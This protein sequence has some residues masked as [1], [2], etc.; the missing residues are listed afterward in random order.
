MS[1]ISTVTFCVALLAGGSVAIAGSGVSY[2]TPDS[3]KWTAGTGPAKGS[4]STT[5]TGN[6]GKT[7]FAVVRV[8]MNDGFANQ[9]HYH[10]NAEY[11]TVLQGTLLFGTG[12]KIDKSK[13]RVLPAGS[14]ITVPA[15][16]HHWSMAKGETMEE[17]AG[18]G[19]QT[20]IPVKRSSM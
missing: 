17:V 19:P 5:L 6:P 18:D 7:G 3:L 20:N 16:L 12:D 9:P 8:R 2:M 15:G 4:T 14:F 11:I 1:R 13:A 10:A